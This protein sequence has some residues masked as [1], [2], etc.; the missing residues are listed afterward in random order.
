[1]RLSFTT[2][3]L[4]LYSYFQV[5]QILAID[6]ASKGINAIDYRMMYPAVRNYLPIQEKCISAWDFT[7]FVMHCIPTGWTIDTALYVI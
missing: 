2:Y 3:I 7:C 6:L 5:I 4:T 1:M